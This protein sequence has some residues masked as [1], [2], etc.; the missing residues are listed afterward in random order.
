MRNIAQIVSYLMLVGVILAPILFF[1]GTISLDHAKLWM[2]I[3]TIGWFIATP[4]W[5]GRKAAAP[6]ANAAE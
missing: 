2:L 4:V 6:A 1:V 5:M 3:V